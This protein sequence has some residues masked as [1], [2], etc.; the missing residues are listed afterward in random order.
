MAALHLAHDAI[1]DVVRRGLA[2][3]LRDDEL[4]GQ[5]EQEVAEFLADRVGIFLAQR[6]V[7]L[8]H[9]LDQVGT[10]R[11]P[12]LRAIPGAPHPQVLHEVEHPLQRWPVLHGFSVPVA[13][14]PT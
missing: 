2:P 10:Q 6:V 3:L 12:R 14:A 9:F 1:G 7:E 4:P 13:Y 8:E 11:L 5:V